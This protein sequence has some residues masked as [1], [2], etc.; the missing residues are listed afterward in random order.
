MEVVWMSEHKRLKELAKKR[1]LEL[2][3]SEEEIFEEYLIKT[4]DMKKGIIVDV[5][6]IKPHYKVAIECGHVNGSRIAQLQLFFDHIEVLPYFSEDIRELVS[7]KSENEELKE[8]IASLEYE[9]RRVE[10]KLKCVR[11]GIRS[12]LAAL[13]ELGDYE[14]KEELIREINLAE[15]KLK[16]KIK[17]L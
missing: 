14:S 4:D 5:A 1:L 8:K 9:L 10:A 16:E 7:L 2:G 11:E 12:I 3:F 6:G 17:G 13:I 15:L